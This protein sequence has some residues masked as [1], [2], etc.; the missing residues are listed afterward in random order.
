MADMEQIQMWKA[1]SVTFSV[2]CPNQPREQSESKKHTDVLLYSQIRKL[3]STNKFQS[4]LLK[5]ESPVTPQET[6]DKYQSYT[7]EITSL[8]FKFL[9]NK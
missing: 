4:L 8:T 6:A 5:W 1:Q 9:L 2:T 7:Y 3:L